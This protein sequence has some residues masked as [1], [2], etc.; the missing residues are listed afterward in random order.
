M[1]SGV[2]RLDDRRL[3]STI[4]WMTNSI[5]DDVW[6]RPEWIARAALLLDSFRRRVGHDLLD[7]SGD[8]VEDARR[9][10]E[11]PLVVVAHGTEADPIL[12]Y[13]NRTALKL[14]E[15]DVARFT[16][17]PS[18]LTAEAPEREE[19]ARLLQRTARDGFVDDYS[20]VRITS[21]GRRF[22]IQ[23]A[24][25]WNVDDDAGTRL[26]QAATFDNWT[27]LPT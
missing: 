15:T 8:A 21:T 5:D 22:F 19:R 9:L 7:R 20:G 12:N 18:R 1:L 17:M 24:I 4:G 10:F 13:G 25:V 16:Q 3:P 14:W 6:K 2:H 27:F 26:G 11:A 23:R